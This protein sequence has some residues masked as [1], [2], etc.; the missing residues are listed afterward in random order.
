MMKRGLLLFMT[1]CLGFSPIAASAQDILTKGSISGT[2]VDINGA[3]IQ[4]AKVTVTGPTG[5]RVVTT[6]DNGAFDVPNLIP[7][8]YTVKAE[9]AGFKI[10]SVADVV[11][12]VG[13]ATTLRV[14]LEAGNI[15]EVVEITAGAGTIDPAS[16]ATSASLNDQLFVNIP[17]QRAV[18]SLFYLAPGT[19][20]GL[21]GGRDNPSIS[22][23]SALDNLYVADGVNIT[24]SAFGGIGTFSRSYGAL[25]TGI[26]TSFI[27]EVQVKTA[28]FEPQYG[29]SQ[30][31]IVNIV[32]Q[33]GSNEFH[34]AIYGFASPKAFEAKRRQPDEPNRVNKF[35]K[36]LH[37]EGYDFGVDVGGYVPGAR[38][39]LFFFGSFNPSVRRQIVRGAEANAADPT[40]S[41]LRILRGP[42]FANRTRTYNYASKVTWQINPNHQLTYSIFGDPSRTNLSSFRT[43]VIDNTTADSVLDYGTRNMALRYSGT[44]TPTLTF[45]SNFGFGRSDFDEIGFANLNRIDDRRGSDAANIRAAGGGIG[46]ARGNFAAIGLGFFE[47]TIS[48]SK[49]FEF[50]LAKTQSLWGQ[51][52]AGI[53]YTF[54]RGNYSGLRERSG[55]KFTIP[56]RNADGSYTTPPVASGQPT[57]VQFRLRFRPASCTQ[58]ALFPV[59]LANGTTVDVPAALQVIRAEFGTPSF[60]TYSNY[61][62]WYA[63]DTWRFSKY[64]T[65]LFGVRWEQERLVGSPGPT[66]QRIGYTFTDQWAPRLGVTV[67]P[68]GRGKTKA[69]YNF[70]HFFEYIPLDL[71]ERSLSAEKDWIGG[72]FVPEFTTVGGVRRA[73]INQFGTVNPVIDAAHFISFV[74]GGVAAGPSISTGDPANPIAPGTKLGYTAEHTFGVEQELGRNFVLSVRYIDRRIKR[75]VEDAASVSPEAAE[76]GI[77]QVY[78]I[79]NISA[80]L[81]AAVNLVPFTYTTGGTVPAGCARDADGAPVFNFDG[82]GN[83]SVCFAQT[84]IDADGNAINVPDGKPDG[85]PDAVRKY[86]A[87]E[88]ELNRRFAN[89]WQMFFNWRIAKLEGNFEGHLRNDNGQTDP[90]IS[91]LFDFTTGDFGLLGDQFA[92]GPLNTDRRHIINVY[93]SYQFTRDKA[94]GVADGLNLGLNV[95]FETGL[96]VSEFNAHPVYLNAGEIPVG[97]R[98][99]LGRTSK[100]IRFDLHADYPF[101]LTENVRLKLIGDF[102][103]VFNSRKVRFP[104][105]FAQLDFGA[106]NPDFLKPA[107]FYNPFNTR[108]GLRLEF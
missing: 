13:K 55:P 106:T 10:G 31:G 59:R 65:G 28:G 52:T 7:G 74:P 104:T 105:Q 8:K 107:S 96:P 23:G 49:R 43:L 19:T 45:D 75:I 42:E 90:A 30:G 99:K 68:L 35:G 15:T 72:W 53:G 85:F 22:G 50:N 64:V 25:G 60:T 18:S 9:H 48:K 46:P 79:A 62:A 73:V 11:V 78:Y 95:H 94:F 41:G 33:S 26:N 81:D 101:A 84:G 103:N 98:G 91:S 61:H 14:E 16:T 36:N 100:Y 76:A 12:Y 70:G 102:F 57:N 1:L 38:D 20:D 89:N 97:G 2:V 66:G 44:W 56:A 77:G 37:E 4:G 29:Q 39:N 88:I 5:E 80:T 6:N 71:A 24:D 93:G 47:P 54:Q 27:K 63:Q 87:V 86:R 69:F 58:C 34:G 3:V 67:D 21:G 82:P 17:V 32:T 83:R 40:N 108:V 51:H 92:V